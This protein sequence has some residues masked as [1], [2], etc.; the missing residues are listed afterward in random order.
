MAVTL[1]DDEGTDH[2]SGS[3]QEGNSMAFTTTAVISETE[4]IMRTL[5][6]GNSLKMLTWKKHTTS[7]ARLQQKMSWILNYDWKR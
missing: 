7:F 1:S 6:M 2:E 3:D 4:I 5:M